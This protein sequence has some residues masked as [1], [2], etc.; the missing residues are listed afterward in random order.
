MDYYLFIKS[1]RKHCVF[2]DIK[3]DNKKEGVRSGTFYLPDT[4]EEK[5]DMDDM[6]D[7]YKGWL[8]YATFL[9]TLDNKL[10]YHSR[11]YLLFIF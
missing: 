10:E 11:E 3:M 7:K 4:R 9:A 8:E 2:T 1:V 6:P 5:E